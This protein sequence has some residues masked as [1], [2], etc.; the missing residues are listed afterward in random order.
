LKKKLLKYS[1]SI[2]VLSAFIQVTPTYASPQVTQEQVNATKGQVDD[3]ETKIMQLD[4]QI[5]VGMDKIQRLNDS[6]KEQKG[7]IEEAKANI[8]QAKN[9]LEAHK[10]VYAE[11]LKSIQYEGKSPIMT[12]AEILVSSKNISEFLTRS[13][14]IS[15]FLQSDSD[16]LNGL[17]QKEQALRDAEEQLHIQLDSLTKDQNALALEQ[18]KIEENKQQVAQ[19]LAASKN[20]LSQQQTQ[21]QVQ[22]KAE[23]DRRAREQA[24][25]IAQQ[26]A[27]QLAKQ[28]SAGNTISSSNGASNLAPSDKVATVIATAE[29]YLGVP[30]VWGGTSPSG[31]DCSGLMQYVFH[32]VG[33][34]L[35]RTAAMQQKVGT[36]I[37]P[38]DVQ[39]GDLVF[40]GPTAY[41][42]GMYIGNGQWINAPE[43]GDVVKIATYNPSKF[44]SAARVL[45]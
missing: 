16:L 26:A 22:Q 33:V 45:H 39:P 3:L 31:F 8:E 43:T 40:Q 9:D 5:S 18:K 19:E 42:V 20:T 36:R 25:L 17:K 28:Q 7:K 37:S 11:R 27:Q 21:L 30:Y 15:Q 32:S 13:T 12:Y 6:I 41:H 1:I 24:A 10:K 38:S 34:N 29:K 23:A 2:A 44:S 14:A 35:P 4:N